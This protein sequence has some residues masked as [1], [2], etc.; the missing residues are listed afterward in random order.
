MKRFWG[1]SHAEDTFELRSK[2]EQAQ[3]GTSVGP[4]LRTSHPEL[5][6]Y[7]PWRGSVGCAV[8]EGSWR[9]SQCCPGAGLGDAGLGSHISRDL[10]QRGCYVLPPWPWLSLLRLGKGREGQSLVRTR[11]TPCRL[12]PEGLHSRHGC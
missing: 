7:P 6:G 12:I 1:W 2:Q 5:L 9:A 11:I 3:V 10:A 4:A 8:L